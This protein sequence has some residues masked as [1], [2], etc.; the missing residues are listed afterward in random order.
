MGEISRSVLTILP[1]WR[2]RSFACHNW[3][4]PVWWSPGL[5][6]K[7]PWIK[8]YLFQ[9]PGRQTTN[10]SDVT[11]VDEVFLAS[12]WWDALFVFKKCKL[13]IA[14]GS[15]QLNVFGWN[16]VYFFV[17]GVKLE[18]PGRKARSKGG[19]QE[20]QTP[21]DGGCC[22]EARVTLLND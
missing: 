16:F 18:N 4:C 7:E 14:D 2:R 6:E 11:A 3:I 13:L 5:L 17:E 9:R 22:I 15:G 19:N 10:K 12:S 21:C 8:W 1:F 20:T